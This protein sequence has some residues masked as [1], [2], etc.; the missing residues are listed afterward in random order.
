MTVA[1]KTGN[2]QQTFNVITENNAKNEN[3]ENNNT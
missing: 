2:Y 1:F 3:R